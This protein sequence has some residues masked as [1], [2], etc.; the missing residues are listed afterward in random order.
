MRYITTDRGGGK[1]ALAERRGAR[2]A[3]KSA[4]GGAGGRGKKNPSPNLGEGFGR[5]AQETTAQVAEAVGMKRVTYEKAKA[6]V[7]A[8]A[9]DPDGFAAVAA[10]MDRTGNVGAAYRG[11]F[12]RGGAGQVLSS[13][14]RVR[15]GRRQ[16]AAAEQARR[17]GKGVDRAFAARAPL[18]DPGGGAAGQRLEAEPAP[19]DLAEPRRH[20][21]AAGPLVG[22]RQL[23]GLAARA[24]VGRHGRGHGRPGGCGGTGRTRQSDPPRAAT[25]LIIARRA[26]S[27]DPAV[28]TN[29]HRPRCLRQ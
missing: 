26:A 15:S 24:A 19:R 7:A 2:K 12:R 11:W 10:A 9:A 4:D 18:P 14:G 13:S 17:P 29:C 1:T 25:R 5:H 16:R 21:G 23:P 6:V 3:G 28:M 22:E 20:V 27:S 8:A